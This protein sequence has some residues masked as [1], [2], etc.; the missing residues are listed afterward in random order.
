MTLPRFARVARGAPRLRGI[1]AAL[2]ALSSVACGATQAQTPASSADPAS[3]RATPRTI[4][5][6]SIA[7]QQVQTR[8]SMP[9]TCQT[10]YIDGVPSIVV[11][12]RDLAQ[13]NTWLGPFAE[14]VGVP[15]CDA[16]NRSGRE[17]RVYMTVGSGDAQRG[18][19]WS[20][21]LARWGEWFSLAGP[22]PARKAPETI[23]EAVQACERVQANPRVPVSCG[24]RYLDDV[25]TLVVGFRD[26]EEAETYLVPMAREVA[27][28]FC[29]AADRASRRAAV[30]ITIAN[31]RARL[32]ECER[33]RWSDW[34]S[35]TPDP[36]SRSGV[37]H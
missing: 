13:A 1:A 4:A 9:V 23:A 24:M 22:A 26:D 33:R 2:A 25:P 36:G 18:R 6:A 20:C 5:E 8:S 30:V 27:G 29:D 12:F 15:F 37:M 17:A 34:F 19:L 10:E 35:L 7:C 31:T 11:G 21:E 3:E 16:A 14:Q 28:P 32:Y